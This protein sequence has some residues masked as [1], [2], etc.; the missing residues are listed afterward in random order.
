MTVYINGVDTKSK[1]VWKDVPERAL[2]LLNQTE[3]LDWTDL[4][5]T[6]YTSAS[7][8][9]AILGLRLKIDSLTNTA[10]AL[11]KV[12]KNGT[13]PSYYPRIRAGSEM[14]DT[15]YADL[16]EYALVGLDSGQVIEYELGV[17]GT[18]QVDVEIRVLG[19]IE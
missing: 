1:V 6:A 8:K 19:Y 2:R 3:D 5:L 4:D 11:W 13:T 10:V 17:T 9:I 15:T 18:I 14:G 16:F 12:R 7:A